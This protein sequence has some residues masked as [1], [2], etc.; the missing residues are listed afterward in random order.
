M[1]T[2]KI[3]QKKEC[4]RTFPSFFDIYLYKYVYIYIYIY[5]YISIYI[6][7]YIL[8]KEQTFSRSFA[9]ERNVLAF[10]Y[11]L[12]KR[13]LRSLRSFPFFAKK[14]CV[15]CVLLGLIS[16]QKL[17]KRTEKKGMFLLKNGKERNVPNG[18]ERGS[19]P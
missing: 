1:Q 9:K 6:S 12:C 16:R 11:V 19:Q 15:L 10:F 17:E 8:K 4:K 14:R 7:I 3:S 2:L 5:L 13:T 18:K